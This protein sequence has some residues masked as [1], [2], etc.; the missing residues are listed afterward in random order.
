VLF[1]EVWNKAARAGDNLL[2]R[3]LPG[4]V[5]FSDHEIGVNA[6]KGNLV[7]LQSVAGRKGGAGERFIVPAPEN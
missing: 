2:Y 5:I 1:A 7:F 3:S 6:P 4:Q